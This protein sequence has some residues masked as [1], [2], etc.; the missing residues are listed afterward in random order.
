LF[1]ASTTSFKK[2]RLI[3]INVINIPMIRSI[4]RC[5]AKNEKIFL[6]DIK[7][8]GII[9]NKDFT[10]PPPPRTGFSEMIF[11]LQ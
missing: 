8:I 9:G 2:R 1:F 7:E 5:Q 4:G 6:P 3:P 10:H 11:Y